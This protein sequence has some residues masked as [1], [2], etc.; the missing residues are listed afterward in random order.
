[1]SEHSQRAGEEV[2]ARWLGRASGLASAMVPRRAAHSLRTWDLG[3]MFV[4]LQKHGQDDI[5][6]IACAPDLGDGDSKA[7]PPP[8]QHRP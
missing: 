8:L 1:M 7:R 4:V 6:A 3:S 2:G 5:P